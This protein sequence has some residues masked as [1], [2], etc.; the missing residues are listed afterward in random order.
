VVKIQSMI[1]QE[2]EST[3][4]IEFSQILLQ[5]AQ[6]PTVQMRIILLEII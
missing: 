3:K 6:T 4:L 1:Y 5:I 2:L